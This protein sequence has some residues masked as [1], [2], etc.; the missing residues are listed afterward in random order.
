MTDDVR[1]RRIC[2]LCNAQGVWRDAAYLAV[3]LGGSVR[4]LQWWECGEHAGGE[5]GDVFGG[6]ATAGRTLHP[7]PNRAWRESVARSFGASPWAP[8]EDC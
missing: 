5:H 2:T 7:M 8:D 3:L 1:I 4:P 6:I